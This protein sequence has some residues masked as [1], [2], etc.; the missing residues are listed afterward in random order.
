LIHDFDNSIYKKGREC[1]NGIVAFA[2]QNF[3][4]PPNPTPPPRSGAAP[5]RGR[6]Q[7]PPFWPSSPPTLSRR[8]HQG[9]R[10]AKPGRRGGGGGFPQLAIWRGRQ[11]PVS[12]IPGGVMQ[13]DAVQ[14]C[15][16]GC[17]TRWRL[18]QGLRAWVDATPSTAAGGGTLGSS[19]I[20]RKP[21]ASALGTVVVV[22]SF[23]GGGRPVCNDVGRRVCR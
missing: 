18:R 8:R 19:C 4:I 15:C 13:E 3:L 23:A 6:S 2:L 5:C 17:R 7:P 10:R 14:G 20:M 1:I 21:D 16:G 9:R 11:R 12:S 22:S